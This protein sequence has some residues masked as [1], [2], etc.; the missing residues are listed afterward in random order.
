MLRGRLT[1]SLLAELYDLEED[2]Y[3]LSNRAATRLGPE[4][5]ATALRAVAAH[6][7]ESLNELREVAR[8]HQVSITAPRALV[9]DT[10]RRVRDRVVLMDHEHA[11]RRALGALHR[12]MDLVALLR[13][14]AQDEGDDRLA[15]WCVRW[16][17]GR[18][19]LIANV[20][21]ELDWFA[22]HPRIAR[23]EARVTSR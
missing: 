18:A 16:L 17:S 21:A 8:A 13:S 2:S 10:L 20:T 14:A 23:L 19:Q 12:G 9:L 4:H 7:N 1:S 5:P 22:R 6:A 11:Y 15:A 3:R